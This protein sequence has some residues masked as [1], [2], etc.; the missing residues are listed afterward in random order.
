M[1]LLGHPLGKAIPAL[2]AAW[3]FQA[4]YPLSI[5]ANIRSPTEAHKS[6]SRNLRRPFVELGLTSLVHKFTN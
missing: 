1:R 2:L 5:G 3:F 6:V 4:F